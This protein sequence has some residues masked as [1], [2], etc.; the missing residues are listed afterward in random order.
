MLNNLNHLNRLDRLKEVIMVKYVWLFPIL[1]MFHDME[2]II[3]FGIWLDKNR[4][5]LVKHFPK[6]S[7]TYNNYSTE[8][9]AL[10]VFE[11]FIICIFF[12]IFSLT[13]NFYGL[14]LG[15]FIAFALHLFIHIVQ[16]II[17]KQYIPAL[18]TSIIL[19]PVS[20]YIVIKAINI[21]DYS[22]ITVFVFGIVGI[23]VIAANLKL[24]HILMNRFTFFLG[25]Q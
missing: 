14:W 15:G 25:K 8:G 20:I 19:L 12:C 4:E 16:S 6:I 17:I 3:G 5:M 24:A 23:A 22:I 10:A 2:E 18:I 9:M 21:L 7:E 11:E 13:F 1:F